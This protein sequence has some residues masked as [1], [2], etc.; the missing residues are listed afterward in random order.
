MS[1]EPGVIITP[2]GSTYVYIYTSK[3]FDIGGYSLLLAINAPYHIP[4]SGYIFVNCILT[5][6]PEN[7]DY[8][9]FIS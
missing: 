5:I 6:W 9:S 7:A 2:L 4:Y 3:Q 8:T 1:S